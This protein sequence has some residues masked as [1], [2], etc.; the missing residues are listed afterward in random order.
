MLE[1]KPGR[2]FQD[3]TELVASLNRLCD[4]ANL[5]KLV[6]TATQRSSLGIQSQ[7][8]RTDGIQS[9]AIAPEMPV[10]AK[11]ARLRSR[12]M[13][14]SGAAVL[15]A[16]FVLAYLYGPWQTSHEPGD[17]PS[18]VLPVAEEADVARQWATQYG[19]NPTEIDW[20]ARRGKVTFGFVSDPKGFQLTSQ[21]K[22]LIAFGT[23]PDDLQSIGIDIEQLSWKGYAG[24]FFGHRKTVIDGQ[25]AAICQMIEVRKARSAAD[26]PIVRLS[27]ISGVLFPSSRSVIRVKEVRWEAPWTSAGS[28]RLEVTFDRTGLSRVLW[29]GADCKELYATSANRRFGADDYQRTWGVFNENGTTWFSRLEMNPLQ[30]E[31]K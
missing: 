20:P 7:I 3:I 21:D 30:K 15:G 28:K 14:V 24:I 5:K 29:N 9:A 8:E 17:L 18:S 16:G 19:V 1:K 4:T 6:A 2:R 13:F 23:M 27:R 11:R 31:V 12:W 22:S 25:V 26:K 10:A